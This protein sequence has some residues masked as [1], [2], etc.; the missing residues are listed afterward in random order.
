MLNV[1][2][3]LDDLYPLLKI[4][5]VKSAPMPGAPFGDGIKKALD[6]CLSL[7]D[8]MG[9]ET[10][11]YD[12]YI[13][14]ISFGEG[15]PFGILCHLDV[16]PEGSLSAWKTD[17]FTPQIIDDKLYCRGALD[18]KSAA[19]S[20][21]SALFELKQAG[22]KFKRRV[23]IILGCDEESGWG[24]IDHYKK[25]ATLP[26]EGFSPDA[27]FPVIYAEKGILHV[28]YRFKK[29]KPFCVKGGVK[30]NVVCDYCVAEGDFTLAEHAERVKLSGN[31]CES[32]GIT[33]HASA[34][35]NGD[36]AIKYLTSFLEKNGFLENGLSDKLFGT[37]S[38]AKELFDE[39][40]NLTFSPNIIETDEDFVYFTVDV[41]YPS[42][43]ERAFVESYLKKIGEYVVISGHD[44]L[45]VDKNCELIKTL[46]SVYKEVTGRDEAPV[47]TGGGTYARALKRGVAFG[48][49]L[50]E[51][52]ASSIH[53]PNEFVTLNTLEK[54]TEIY[55]LAIKKICTKTPQ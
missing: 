22:Y 35:E 17:P 41:R 15:E 54:M 53:M 11:N 12:G 21:L 16:V 30:V 19:I 10:K 2:K 39:T 50:T 3:L 36:N 43:F 28:K 7:A 32:F 49:S 23:I 1:K 34:P 47:A 6:Y 51:E 38:D 4:K 48:P 42:T 44:P 13:G 55:Y 45:F 37:A 14:E 46:M 31:I 5:S 29:N 33:A 52:E 26:E 27:Q 25:C 8:K 24:C 40:G 20:V 9:F 18:D